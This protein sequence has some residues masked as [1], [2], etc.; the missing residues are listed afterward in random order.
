MDGVDVTQLLE[1][2]QKLQDRVEDVRFII[3]MIIE[4]Q[5]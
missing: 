4:Q 1:E 5:L 2:K 3:Y